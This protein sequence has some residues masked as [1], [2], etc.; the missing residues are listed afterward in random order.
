MTT[1]HM[2]PAVRCYPGDDY[3]HLNTKANAAVTLSMTTSSGTSEDTGYVRLAIQDRASGETL[4]AVD[5]DP[6]QA[7]L[8]TSGRTQTWPAQITPHLDR[9]GKRMQNMRVDLPRA[10]EGDTERDVKR[11]VHKA[12]EEQLPD[13]W[14]VSGR[15]F[16]SYDTPRMTNRAQRYTIV[17]RWVTP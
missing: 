6:A 16:D 1:D 9:V 4:V 3:P 2:D 12:V 17:R 10:L 5:L 7:W 13:D 11:D 15:G 14:G 8:L